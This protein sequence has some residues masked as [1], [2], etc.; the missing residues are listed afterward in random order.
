MS[1]AKST[2]TS[3]LACLVHLW[4]LEGRPQLLPK[5]PRLVGS[6]PRRWK[7]RFLIP[8]CSLIRID[9]DCLHTGNGLV[10]A[11][12]LVRCTCLVQVRVSIRLTERLSCLSNVLGW[13]RPPDGISRGNCKSLATVWF[14]PMTPWF[15][16]TVPKCLGYRCD[17][18]FESV[19][20][21]HSL[22]VFHSR[23]SGR[24]PMVGFH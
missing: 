10:R 23:Y 4:L 24:Y 15:G 16:R 11:N 14:G 17:V 21:V 18:H 7:T 20:A 5:C 3:E 13:F 6:I 1:R 2:S 12:C 9:F 19:S 8:D 22:A